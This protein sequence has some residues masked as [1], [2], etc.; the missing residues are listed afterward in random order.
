MNR[1]IE[2]SSTWPKKI[3]MA[4][5]CPA[6]YALG[7]GLR[8]VVWVQGC[9]LHCRGCTA[10][11]FIPF[12]KAS[13]ISPEA[14][15]DLLLRQPVEGITISGGEP[16]MQSGLLA[17]MVEIARSK[18]DISVLCY[19]GFQMETLR[20]FDENS[21]VPALLRQIDTLIDSPFVERLNDNR[22]LRGS[23]NQ[24]VFHLTDRMRAFDFQS[25]IRKVEIH[26]FNGEVLYV[27]VPPFQIVEA[28]GFLK[29][30]LLEL[31]YVRP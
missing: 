18:R 22:G 1:Q 21:G 25:G 20:K 14:L 17:E 30:Q 7:P 16:F 11:E 31:E 5:T 2:Q 29:Q 12:T 26:V 8:S 27:G 13:L 28:S 15:A 10:P 3:N 4:A 19:T 24:R 6:T 23:S 9:P